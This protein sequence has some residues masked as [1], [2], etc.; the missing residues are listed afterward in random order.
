MILVVGEVSVFWLSVEVR[1]GF[2]IQGDFG[3]QDGFGIRGVVGNC[4]GVGVG[5]YRVVAD[6][7]IVDQGIA[8][9]GVVGLDAVAWDVAVRGVFELHCVG[10]AVDSHAVQA[11]AD[12]ESVVQDEAVPGTV[13]QDVVDRDV[14]AQDVVA[15]DTVADAAAAPDIG[16]TDFAFFVDYRQFFEFCLVV[17]RTDVVQGVEVRQMALPAFSL[18]SKV[19]SAPECWSSGF[20]T[21]ERCFEVDLGYFEP[22]LARWMVHL[23]A[24]SK[25]LVKAHLKAHSKVSLELHSKAYSVYNSKEAY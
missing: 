4:T 9:V 25:A 2:G 6:Q 16:H 11:V 19:C 20:V 7:G 12:L 5:S 1:S 18:G 23:K 15:R 24:H 10:L 8:G 22:C 13:D 17:V 21:L 3:I 14:V